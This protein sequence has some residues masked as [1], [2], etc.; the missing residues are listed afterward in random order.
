MHV[1]HKCG[2]IEEI[3]IFLHFNFSKSCFKLEILHVTVQ[4]YRSNQNVL[5]GG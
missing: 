1:P 4:L 5:Y 3:V 2:F